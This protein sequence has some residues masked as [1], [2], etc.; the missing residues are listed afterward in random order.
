MAG[1]GRCRLLD[2]RGP[3]R[4]VRDIAAARSFRAVDAFPLA[5]IDVKKRDPV[6]DLLAWSAVR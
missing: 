4:S 5:Q 2:G 1:A 3:A 6:P